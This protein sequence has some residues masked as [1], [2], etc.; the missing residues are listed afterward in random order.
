MPKRVNFDSEGNEYLDALVEFD[1]I[2]AWNDTYVND[3]L[4]EQI[5]HNIEFMFWLSSSWKK[6]KGII[7]NNEDV[8]PISVPLMRE[9]H[10]KKEGKKTSTRS[11]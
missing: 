4:F 10:S 7:L 6:S 3:D 5:H 9:N 8:K 2:V 1:F 11:L